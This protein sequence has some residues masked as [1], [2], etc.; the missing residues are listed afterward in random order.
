MKKN[1]ILILLSFFFLYNNTI[2]AQE[3]CKSAEKFCCPESHCNSSAPDGVAPIGVMSDHTHHKKGLMFSYRF[4]NMNMSGNLSGS[5]DISNQE[6]FSNYMLAP[7]D[8]NMQM[9][10]VG[11]MYGLSDK[12]TLMA[13]M[14]IHQNKMNMNMMNGSEHQ[15][16]SQ[17]I[18]D[19]KISAIVNAWKNNKH[20]INVNAGVSLPT[21]N[22]G[23]TEMNHLMHQGGGHEHGMETV[24]PYPMRL[25]SGTYDALLGAT[26]LAKWNKFSFGLQSQNIIRTGENDRDYSLGNQYTINTWGAYRINN[27]MSI[28][29]RGE[30]VELGSIDGKDIDLMAMMS[31]TN[32][33]MN[34]GQDLIRGY[35]GVNLYF[36]DFWNGLHIGTEFGMPIY[37]NVEGVQMNES[38]V[39]SVGVR[40]DVL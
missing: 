17:G 37:Q 32:N 7:D 33:V 4:M 9:H 3:E 30:G 39:F 38:N 10:M 11:A 12:I 36:K 16:S 15:H 24:M 6:I 28:S 14:N 21:G 19:L 25:G 20:S 26:Y 40:F 13:M 5:S 29:L 2:T 8:M 18:G 1:V 34:S 35:G 27:W 23:I 31:P 22:V